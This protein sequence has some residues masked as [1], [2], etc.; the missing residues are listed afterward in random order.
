MRPQGASACLVYT[1]GEC[2]QTFKLLCL[3]RGFLTIESA[4]GKLRYGKDTSSNLLAT[5]KELAHLRGCHVK[6]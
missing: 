2:E 5:V 4:F 3:R 6:L 1:L